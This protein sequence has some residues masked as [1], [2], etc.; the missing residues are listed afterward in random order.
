MTSCKIHIH[1]STVKTYCSWLPPRLFSV[2]VML[3]SIRKLLCVKI[4]IKKKKK[5]RDKQNKNKKEEKTVN[6]GNAY[7][8]ENKNLY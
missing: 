3:Y 7:G 8:T 5:D 6:A 2:T 4:T 1:G